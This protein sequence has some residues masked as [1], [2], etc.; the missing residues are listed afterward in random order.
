VPSDRFTLISF[1]RRGNAGTFRMRDAPTNGYFARDTKR[2][3]KVNVRSTAGKFLE[4][5]LTDCIVSSYSRA[6]DGITTATLN[7]SSY[8][9]PTSVRP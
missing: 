4:I 2:N 5:Q 6:G 7:F 9:G 3:G 1:E 8:S